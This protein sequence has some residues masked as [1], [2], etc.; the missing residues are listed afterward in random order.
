MLRG[1]MRRALVLAV[2]SAL[3]FLSVG[4]APYHNCRTGTNQSTA[5]ALAVGGPLIGE[6]YPCALANDEY[7]SLANTGVFSVNLGGWC[8]TDGE[9]Y[10]V[11]SANVSIEGMGSFVV[12]SNASSYRAAYGISPD[13]WLED[14]ELG[15]Y[16]SAKGTFRLGDSGDS[17]RLISP[18]GIVVDSVRFGDSAESV[19]AWLGPP[20]PALRRG[21]VAKRIV[22]DGLPRDSDAACDWMPFREH[23]YGH[24]DFAPYRTSLPG[25]AVTAFTSPD[26]SLDA[27]L[28]TLGNASQSILLCTY[29]LSSPAVCAELLGAHA[30]GADVRAL[31]EGA[32]TGGMDSDEVACLSVL[33]RVGMDVRVLR[34]SVNEGGVQ[35]LRPRSVLLA[36]AID[37]RTPRLPRCFHHRPL[38]GGKAHDLQARSHPAV[39]GGPSVEHQVGG[40]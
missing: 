39:P 3:L 24:T 13:L 9:G 11:F 32:P 14:P 7:V 40:V 21:E 18:N 29:E 26:C 5:Q 35:Q 10:L 23:R 19:E 36:H 1:P 4:L 33:A 27:V 6:F 22:I 20:V 15:R 30:R 37:H 17:I 28:E 16:L 31:V 34:G 25:G 8:L 2:S 12:A 38:R